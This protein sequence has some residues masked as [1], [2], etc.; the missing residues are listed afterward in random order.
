MKKQ[1]VLGTA[2][3]G[4]RYGFKKNS[5]FNNKK[6]INK[7]LSLALNSGIKYLDTAQSYGKSEN[8]IGYF[9]QKKQ[10]KKF[11]LITKL[12]P[13]LSKDKDSY[14]IINSFF[15]LSLK[16]LKVKKIE[17]FFIHDF[18]DLKK[19]KLKLIKNLV[20]LKKKKLINDIGVS[21]YNP[22]DFYYALK[23]KEIKH[24]QIPFNY[25]DK[26]WG[27]K[28]FI[29]KINKRPEIKIHVRS[30]FLRGILLAQKKY[31]PS[32]FKKSNIFVD[33]IEIICKE[34]NL[35]KLE[36]C[37]AYV[38]SFKWVDFILFGI[39]NINH[40]KEIIKASKIKKLKKNNVK[41]INNLFANYNYEKRILTPFLW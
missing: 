29:K 9:N 25:L 16:K 6:K 37:F 24:F 10:N 13:N 3:F 35:N 31:W 12:H 30:I 17:V 22:K 2:Q 26:R 36:L 40:L 41:K 33:K 27:G 15:F 28:F 5:I 11:K 23:Y 8:Y 34:L 32:W 4:G 39:D 19:Y 18:S 21:V 1:L 20:E 38:K 7:I 14:K